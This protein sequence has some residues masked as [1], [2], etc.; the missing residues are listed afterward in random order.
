MQR[1]KKTSERLTL[2]IETLEYLGVSQ[3]GGHVDKLE[4]MSSFILPILE[5]KK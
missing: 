4:R 2:K 1:Q 3:I 5:G